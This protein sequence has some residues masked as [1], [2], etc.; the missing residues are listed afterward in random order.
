MYADLLEHYPAAV[1]QKRVI[2]QQDNSRPHTLKITMD[3]IKELNG[4]E[5]HPLY[6]PDLA[7]SDYYL[8]KFMADF[9]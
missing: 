9:L 8:F 6:S 3:K 5:P 1:K 7:H 2:L 4:I